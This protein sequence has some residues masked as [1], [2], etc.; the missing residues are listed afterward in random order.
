MRR[1]RWTSSIV[2]PSSKNCT[3]S[4]SRTSVEL[5]CCSRCV[6][7]NFAISA[8]PSRRNGANAASSSVPACRASM[9]R[10]ACCAGSMASERRKAASAS[11]LLPACARR[12]PAPRICAALASACSARRWSKPVAA[13][14]SPRACST[15][16]RASSDA[17]ASGSSSCSSRTRVR[18]QL[19]FAQTLGVVE[20]PLS[21]GVDRMLREG[22]RQQR[23]RASGVAAARPVVG[24]REQRADVQWVGFTPLGEDAPRR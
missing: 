4:W 14:W 23:Q 2:E 17:G 16:A 20:S 9:R 11:A 24:L 6:G 13:W 21:Y 12:S 10:N 19:C 1:I 5:A 18:A 15:S 8:S 3:I 22:L 7:S